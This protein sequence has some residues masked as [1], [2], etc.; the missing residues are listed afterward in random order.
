VSEGLALA[1][2]QGRTVRS[3]GPSPVDFPSSPEEP[4]ALK[5]HVVQLR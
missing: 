2:R 3:L 1:G 5:V 4:P